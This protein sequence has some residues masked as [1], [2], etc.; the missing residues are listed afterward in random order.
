VQVAQC[1]AFIEKK[2]GNVYK[3]ASWKALLST[4][5]SICSMITPAK[6]VSPVVIGLAVIFTCEC[7]EIK[8]K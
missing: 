6:N 7:R 8:G 2:F 3:P 4:S 1:H 5:D